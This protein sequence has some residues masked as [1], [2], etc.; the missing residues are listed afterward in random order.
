[1]KEGRKEINQ[2]ATRQHL[3]KNT[4]QILTLQSSVVTHVVNDLSI[5]HYG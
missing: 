2:L 4:A 3:N 1:M 5:L